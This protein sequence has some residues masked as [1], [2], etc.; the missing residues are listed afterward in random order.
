M[1]ERGGGIREKKEKKEKKRKEK[2]K[3]HHRALVA[4]PVYY[5]PSQANK[6]PQH[7]RD[8]VHGRQNP[9]PIHFVVFFLSRNTTACIEDLSVVV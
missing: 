3:T 5:C 1:L 4:T 7:D 9:A 2:K 8:G 6:R